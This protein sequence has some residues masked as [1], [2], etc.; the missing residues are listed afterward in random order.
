MVSLPKA[1]RHEFP[2]LR[3]S[4]SISLRLRKTDGKCL[5]RSCAAGDFM[6]FGHNAGRSKPTKENRGWQI[7]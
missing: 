5:S 7:L 1:L 2:Y 3:I 6:H 4:V